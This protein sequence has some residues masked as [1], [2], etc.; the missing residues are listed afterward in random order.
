MAENVSITY[1][2]GMIQA[3]FMVGL[4]V[5][6]D[7]VQ[8]LLD[9]TGILAIASDIVTFIAEG[10]LGIWFMINGVQFTSG[11]RAVSKFLTVF[12]TTIIE[13]IPI[14]DALPTLTIGTIFL[15]HASR[16]EDREKFKDA[17]KRAVY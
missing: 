3:C 6:A 15:I 5:I 1:R 4:C 11:K 10:T 8:V 16:K 13:L 9:L 17:Q 2:I 14:V 12:G 7:L